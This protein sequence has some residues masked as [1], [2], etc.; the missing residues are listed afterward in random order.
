MTDTINF[1]IPATSSRTH[2]VV[3]ELIGRGAKNYIAYQKI[4]ESYSEKRMRLLGYCLYEKLTLLSQYRSAYIALSASELSRF[5]FQPGDTEGVVNYALSIEGI[6][7]SALFLEKQESIK[8]SFR[9]KGNFDANLF[10]RKYFAGGGHMNAAGGDSYNSLQLTVEKFVQAL[11][12]YKEQLV[13]L[14]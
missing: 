5:D 6:H 11:E 4:F 7:F 8:A 1:K 2:Q 3:A 13:R 9:S 10:A 14:K 12:E